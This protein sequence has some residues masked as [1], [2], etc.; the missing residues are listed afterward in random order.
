MSTAAAA[1]CLER[2]T[3]GTIVTTGDTTRCDLTGDAVLKENR[4]KGERGSLKS[5]SATTNLNEGIILVIGKKDVKK[6]ILINMYYTFLDGYYD[7]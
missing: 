1:A 6:V 3:R 4:E 7:G 2:V 5:L